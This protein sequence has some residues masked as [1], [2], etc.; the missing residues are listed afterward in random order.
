MQRSLTA[1]E[2]V[3]ESAWVLIWEQLEML[4]RSDYRE[5]WEKKQ[6]WYAKNGFEVG[7]NLSCHRPMKTAV[8]MVKL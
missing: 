2:R 4:H 3:R 1:L 6:T 5:A 7:E 8:S